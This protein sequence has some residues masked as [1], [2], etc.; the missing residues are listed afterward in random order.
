MRFLIMAALAAASLTLPL[1]AW[2]QSTN[3]NA[4]TP[5]GMPTAT[6]AAPY[7]ARYFPGI[8]FRYVLPPAER[9]YGY[10]A[11]PRVSAYRSRALRSCRSENFW[12]WD[13]A[14]RCS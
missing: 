1:E 9:I 10:Y 4:K 14:G 13:G 3:P 6:A 12:L 7:G 8:G 5:A 2:A 11:G